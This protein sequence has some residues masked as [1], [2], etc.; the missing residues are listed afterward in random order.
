MSVNTVRAYKDVINL[1]RIYLQ[2]TGVTSIRQI[3]F[4]ILNRQTIYHFLDW[5][6]KDR[7][8]TVTTR[9]HRLAVLKSFFKYAAQEDPTLMIN[10]IEISQIPTKKAP[11]K[12]IEY[13]SE[14]A[15]TV[16]LRQPAGTLKGIRDAFLMVLM[17]DTGA[18][19]QEILD[20][21]VKDI[22]VSQAIP[23]IYITGKGG[24]MRVVPLL[25]K[26]IEHYDFY[27]NHYHPQDKSHNEDYLFYTVI[28]G[29]VG[30]MSPDN[31]ASFLKRYGEM[32]RQQCPEVPERVHPHL[33]RHTKAMHLYQLGMP[34]SYIKDFLGHASINTTSIYAKTDV[35]M[36]R[37]ALEKAQPKNEQHRHK[38]AWLD[39]EET[40]LKLC[41]L[42]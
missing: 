5:L 16:L 38:P 23:C 29:K 8:C 39:D 33:I 7:L 35:S 10:Y 40:L 18:R 36:L 24:R 14:K 11:S 12:K 27:M 34:L 13:L 30:P 25:N 26:T 32:A 19:V 1:L 9:N 4:D 21:R 37:A 15:L 42:K 3:T 41:G 28:K 31:V 17:Y 20:L 6:E 2:T 22:H